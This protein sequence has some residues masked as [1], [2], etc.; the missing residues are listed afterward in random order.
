[1]KRAVKASAGKGRRAALFLRVSKRTGEQTTENQR[2]DVERML[3][4]RGV[5]IV[6]RYVT[7]ESSVKDRVTF[8]R[9]MRE[10][11]EGEFNVLGIW[12]IDRFGRSMVGN[13]QAVLELDRR[14]VE[15]ASVREPWLD[16]RGPVRELL[17]A[18]FSWVA[19]QERRR[20]VER[21]RAGME[22]AKRQG[23]RIG[24]PPAAVN[25]TIARALRKDGASE[26]EIAKRLGVS[27]TTLR[28]AIASAGWTEK[29]ASRKRV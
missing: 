19:E 9:M 4:A 6:K 11:H 8:E 16:T 1:M 29:G 23:K 24:R 18:I 14:G 27:R 12:S 10:A 22:R 26:R 13:M 25:M 20:L 17:I 28:R 15:V 2:P 21:T 7:E 5:E 3:K